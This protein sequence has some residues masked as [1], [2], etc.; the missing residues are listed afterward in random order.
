[1]RTLVS[2]FFY[3]VGFVL[4]AFLYS[5]NPDDLQIRDIARL[6]QSNTAQQLTF[7][8]TLV[9]TGLEF[10]F[11]FTFAGAQRAR[12]VGIATNMPAPI[13]KAMAAGA[14]NEGSAMKC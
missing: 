8:L 6:V 9:L 14:S 11:G 10:M 7:L 5:S 3:A 12:A 1:M 4:I 13:A 2:N